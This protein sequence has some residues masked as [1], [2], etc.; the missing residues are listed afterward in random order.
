MATPARTGPGEASASRQVEEAGGQVRNWDITKRC[1]ARHGVY[2]GLDGAVSS[3]HCL[4][5]SMG[6]SA[7]FLLG[8]APLD[9]VAGS[10]P[11]FPATSHR[12]ALK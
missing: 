2:F 4:P 11:P 10:L 3:Q 6:S 8:P 5:R 9:S 7:H 1:G 12:G